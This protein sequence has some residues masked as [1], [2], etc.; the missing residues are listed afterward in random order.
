[1]NA[2]IQRNTLTGM[3]CLAFVFFAVPSAR[4]D[5]IRISG[6]E[7][8]PYISEHAPHYGFAA[9][10]IAEAF[11]QVGIDVEWGFFPWARSIKVAQDGQWD[12]SAVWLE[13]EERR[14]HFLLSEPV[15]PSNW[16][17]FHLTTDDFDWAE[18]ADLSPLRI[19]GTSSY[20]Y[21]EAFERAE[22]A[23]EIQ[24]FRAQSDGINLRNLLNGRID[25]F[26][27]ELLVTYAQIRDTLSWTEAVQITHHDLPIHVQPLHLLI[28]KHRAD[29]QS[30]IER[31]NR[32]LDLLKQN[33]RHD[34]IVAAGYAG[35]YATQ[36]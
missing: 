3:L 13:S 18:V 22:R 15:A 28:S 32:G 16:V 2:I 4:A 33:G 26:P 29:G 12:G 17:F 8:Q 23:A 31:F 34:E 35:E 20:Y 25:L 7:W 14:E 36:P 10:L 21:G 24:V 9:H 30:L 11:A 27:G 1:M 19:G 6:G 5:Q